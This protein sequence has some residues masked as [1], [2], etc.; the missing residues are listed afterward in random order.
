M[1]AE[2]TAAA[3]ARAPTSITMPNTASN[4]RTQASPLARLAF[5][6]MALVIVYASLYPFEGWT[7]TGIAPWAFLT[8]PWPRYQT[9]FD[10]ATNVVAYVPLGMLGVFALYPRVR[11]VGAVLLATLAGAALS[12]SMEALQTYLPFRVSSNVDFAL[13]TCGSLLG[14]IVAAPLAAP[15]LDR[16]PLRD[17]RRRLFEPQASWGLLIVLAWF[18]AQLFPQALLFGTGEAVFALRD[19]VDAIAGEPVNW[20]LLPHV[21]PED[22][23]V[24]EAVCAASALSGAILLLMQLARAEAPRSVF[25][26]L[27]VVSAVATRCFASAVA[28]G[29][30]N[31]F[32]WDTP[33]A[34]L[35]LAAGTVLALAC[36]YAPRGVQ[37]S[38]AIG[39]LSAA[40]AVVNILPENPYFAATLAGWQQGHWINF[41]GLLHVVA[42]GWPYL[43]IGYLLMHRHSTR[44]L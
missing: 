12:F 13:N 11:R 31:V 8:A 39:L 14:A 37:R 28:F 42:I 25:I 19:L 5:A 10:M 32:A 38:F 3:V 30:D 36:S 24:A 40:V 23:V 33:G 43:A 1:V 29:I 20:A 27:F 21:G 22:M 17:L 18:A 15:V 6:C 7:D 41:N 35:G 44:A 4:P 16:G 34:R 26:A 9:T 2:P